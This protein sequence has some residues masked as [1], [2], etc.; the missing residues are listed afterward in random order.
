[1]SLPF[2][3]LNMHRALMASIE[4]TKTL[5]TS[6][7][8]CLLTEPCTN[9]NKICYVPNNVICLPS[10]TLSDRPRTAIFLPRHTP[11]VFLDQLSNKDCTAA[12]LDF[13]C[14][15]AIVASVYLDYN[16]PVVQDWLE[17][18]LQYA[19]S[20]KYPILIAMDSN[21]HSEL[22]GP[23][24][25][26][27]GVDF[28]EFIEQHTLT[29]ENKGNTPTFHSFRRGRHND[30]HIDVTLTKDFIPLQNWRVHDTTYNGSD[31]HTITWDIPTSLPTP[32]MIRPWAK[33]DWKLFTQIIADYD[34]HIP[35][36]FTTFK[37][38]K[39]L[40][41]WYKVVQGALNEA[42]PLRPARPTPTEM[43]WY[44]DDLHFLHKR[45]K[46]KYIAHRKS[47]TSHKH[48]QFV[49][50][51]RSYRKACRRGRRQ[52]WRLFVEKTPD[53]TNMAKLFKIA[54]RRD[55]RTINTIKR[56]D[57]TMTQPGME[58]ITALTNVHFPAAQPGTT[59]PNLTSANKITSEDLKDKY[60]DWIT[61]ELVRKAMRLFKP[62]KAAGPDGLK[63]VVFKY[64]PDNAIN[65]LTI[66]YRACIALG[67]TPA[68]WRETKVIFLP[69]PGKESY[70]IPKSYRPI[71][72]SNF[73]LKCLERLVVWK[74]DRDMLPIHH[75]QHGFTKGKS[76]ES[77]ISDTANYIE[78]TIFQ[79]KHHC[80][81]VF[82]HISSAFDSIS[83]QHIRQTL[84]DH[85][86]DP[87][88]VEWYYSY[89]GRRYLEV[90]L[91]GDTMHLTT[92]TG[93]PQG[94][95]C[96]ARFW[97]IAFNTAIE[98]INSEGIIGNGYAD[99]CAALIG[100]TH[101]HNMIE[102]MQTMLDKLVAWGRT[103]GLRFNPQK[104]VAIMFTR[105]TREFRRLVRMD[106][107]LLPYSD[108]VVYLGV[109]LDKELKWK[110]HIDNKI[111]KAKCLLMKMAGITHSYWG[112]Q[113]KL[114]RWMY[115][116][117]VRPVI[118]YA[119]MVW[120]HKLEEES[121]IDQ[122]RT[123]QRRA[124]NTIVKVP[125]S[126]PTRG[127]EII[128]DIL[129]LHLHIQKEGLAAFIRINDPTP[130]PWEGIFTNLTHSI[131]HLKYWEYLS[132]D[133]GIQDFHVELDEC[134][135]LNHGNTFVIDNGSFVD[136]E[137]CQD[138]V[139]CNVY[140]D[141]SK[142]NG[143]VGAG[144]FI[145]RGG[146]PIVMDMFRL[147]DCA[148]VFQAELTAIREAANTLHTIL[149][150]TAVKFFVDSQA[151]L[152]TLQ[153]D[154]ITSK[155]ALQTATA[156]NR[157]PATSVTLVWTKAHV[158]NPGND[159]ADELAKQGTT[160]PMPLAIPTPKSSIKANLK[161]CI[162]NKWQQEWRTY[163][164]ARQT[165]LYHDAPNKNISNILI[166]WPRLK[167]GRYIRAV[168]GHNN[169]LYHLHNM[170]PSISPICRFC[171]Q[172]NEEFYHLAN[173]CPPLW[174]E[175]HLISAQDPDHVNNWTPHQIATFAFL[176]PIDTAFVKPLYTTE[177][178]RPPP[179]TP[180]SD[181]SDP[182]DP[183][184]LSQN[185]TD[186]TS[187][188]LATESDYDTDDTIYVDA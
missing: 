170:D 70:D 36:N 112:P 2:I 31:H 178:Q 98:I 106:G 10:T 73:P 72:L 30:T 7:A 39:L 64:L 140:T 166:Q 84:L 4:L 90:E 92:A 27:R 144:I 77:A 156:L 137:S 168:T 179:A 5:N 146:I 145:L 44:G 8:I 160:L 131:S 129:P 80:L 23:E 83:I 163:P 45:V 19:D 18:L 171:L 41:R 65:I 172:A 97:L 165:K 147:P 68:Q 40:K 118:S 61:P 29:I 148:T 87:E 89:L 153:A 62:N 75:K 139:D 126:T 9:Q 69:K 187:M 136:M 96:S 167:L 21:A 116:G 108:S 161:F 37:T 20:K 58:T 125:R 119:A 155:L 150:L 182:D 143:R 159:K 180:T 105:S 174:W 130:L 14:G 91:H 124:I 158:G 74:M 42:C 6:N 184:P 142:L 120:A 109:T 59:N 16:L 86:G 48:K 101:P 60:N 157:I 79:D 26:A 28:E 141:G 138:H 85:G 63:P 123:L 76:T 164:D 24:T 154:F 122:L 152:R 100:G 54:Q 15:R 47:L 66:I 177:N 149:D 33:A 121:L 110:T 50:A 117:I 93:F 185:D 34:F 115:T 53:Q 17:A 95:V 99:D 188:E 176:P 113:P 102:K 43:D 81:G 173:D 12:I 49:K 1:M 132:N 35:D 88:L 175:R 181:S 183:D 22:Y 32:P 51:K 46:R 151:A 107:D 25:N 13:P 11:H 169:L 162:N 135:V 111:L 56:P 94:G 134:H 71:S 103:C 127:L 82:L 55:R 114:M 3:Q 104:T 78:Q 57:G 128:L 38:D 133:L 67:H 52:S 186:N